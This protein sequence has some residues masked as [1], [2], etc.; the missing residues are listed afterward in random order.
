ML[1]REPKLSPEIQQRLQDALNNK[2]HLV[3]ELHD[4]GYTKQEIFNLYLQFHVFLRDAGTDEEYDFIADNVLDGLTSWG[5]P[6]LLPDEPDA[7]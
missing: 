7:Q 6:R 5:K 2:Q 4:E 3:N 1:D